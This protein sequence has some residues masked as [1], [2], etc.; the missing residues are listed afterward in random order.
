MSFQRRLAI[1]PGSDML[2]P[3]QAQRILAEYQS[4]DYPRSPNHH[5]GH[6]CGPSQLPSPPNS[7]KLRLQIP[8]QNQDVQLDERKNGIAQRWRFK[9]KNR[10]TNI[11]RDIHQRRRALGSGRQNPISDRYAHKKRQPMKDCPDHQGI[12]STTNSQCISSKK[13][14]VSGIERHANGVLSHP[15][16]ARN[17]FIEVRKSNIIWSLRKLVLTHHQ[18]PHA[19]FLP[20]RH[21]STYP[22]SP[23]DTSTLDSAPF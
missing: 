11:I 15:L 3:T 23:R 17:S 6:G 5:P 10:P 14:N 20:G 19:P 13:G 16:E 22:I 1:V 8:E 4:S 9:L 12:Y 7:K 18:Q 21:L 2:S